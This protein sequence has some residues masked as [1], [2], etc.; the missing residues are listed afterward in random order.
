MNDK[1]SNRQCVAGL[2][3]VI[4]CSLDFNLNSV[5][6]MCENDSYEGKKKKEFCIFKGL[7]A[8]TI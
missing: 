7:R 6:L 3:P 2:N 4:I 8:K 5:S 1:Y